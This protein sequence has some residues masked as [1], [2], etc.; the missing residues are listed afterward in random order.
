MIKNLRLEEQ[1]IIKDAR[2]LFG[3]K[4]ELDNIAIKDTSNLFR[5]EQ[6]RH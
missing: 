4:K 1:N 5:L 3:L 6:K 2:N